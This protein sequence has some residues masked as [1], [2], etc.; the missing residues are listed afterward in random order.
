MS[1]SEAIWPV[2][3]IWSAFFRSVFVLQ[4][5]VTVSTEESVS[6]GGIPEDHQDTRTARIFKPAREATQTAWNNTKVFNINLLF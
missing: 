6:I 2:F 1:R 3:L 4:A 5:P